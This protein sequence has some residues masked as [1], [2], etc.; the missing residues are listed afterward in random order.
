MHCDKCKK[1]VTQ[2][3]FNYSVA[4][5]EKTLCMSCQRVYTTVTRKVVGD[6][7]KEVG[8]DLHCDKCKKNVSQAV[9]D[10]S[11]KRHE[12]ALCMNCQKRVK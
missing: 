7:S 1:T 5:Y 3:V 8:E 6:K 10:Y 11:K 4:K 12:R 2:A 9:Y